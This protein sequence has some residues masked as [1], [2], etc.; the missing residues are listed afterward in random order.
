MDTSSSG[1]GTWFG[2]QL[3]AVAQSP[4]AVLVQTMFVAPA[5]MIPVARTAQA[6]ALKSALVLMVLILAIL[7]SSFIKRE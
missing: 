5:G 6:T 4:L 1:L 3:A 7:H 2:F